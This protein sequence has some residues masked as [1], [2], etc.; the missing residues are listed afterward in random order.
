MGE[1]H[2]KVELAVVIL[3]KYKMCDGPNLRKVINATNLDSVLLKGNLSE[4]KSTYQ[5][6]V[7]NLIGSINVR[8]QDLQSSS[9][10]R[11]TVIVCQKNWP[12]RGQCYQGQIF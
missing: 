4:F 10:I 12:A 5:T 11:S 7:K 3:E 6:L 2:K 9:V 1:V 8:F